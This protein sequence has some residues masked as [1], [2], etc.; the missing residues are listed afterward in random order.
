MSD[1][2]LPVWCDDRQRA[3][4]FAAFSRQLSGPNALPC[5]SVQHWPAPEERA[6]GGERSAPSPI[7]PRNMANY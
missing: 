5:L 6:I 3:A 7:L 4:E 1:R 2:I